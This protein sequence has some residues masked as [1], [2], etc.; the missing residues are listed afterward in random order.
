[1]VFCCDPAAIALTIA[2]AGARKS[3]S[4]RREFS[5]SKIS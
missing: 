5:S 1:M 4:T 2:V 3:R